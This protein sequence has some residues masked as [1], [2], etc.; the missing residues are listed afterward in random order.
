MYDD[1][2][3]QQG[4]KMEIEEKVGVIRTNRVIPKSN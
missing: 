4:W 1:M 3:N 2:A